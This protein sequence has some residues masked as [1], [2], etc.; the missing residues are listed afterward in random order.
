ME[1]QLHII[2]WCFT[3]GNFPF[4]DVLDSALPPAGVGGK[5]MTQN[6]VSAS[7]L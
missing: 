1:T 7:F 4:Y 6:K 5:E 2:M 3:A